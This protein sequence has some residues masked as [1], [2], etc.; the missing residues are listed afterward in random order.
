MKR[1]ERLHE[2]AD[3][4]R[5]KAWM[6]SA[7]CGCVGVWSARVGM[8]TA[9]GG[10]LVLALALAGLRFAWWHVEECR[11]LRWL[12]RAEEVWEDRLNPK[13]KL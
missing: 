12:A 2:W 5:A 6:V 7:V 10:V 13:R 1:S 3:H 4:E 11:R 9:P 8:S